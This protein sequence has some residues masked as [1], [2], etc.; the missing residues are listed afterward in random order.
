MATV[1]RKIT[2]RDIAQVGVHRP[3]SA[4]WFGNARTS[5]VILMQTLS[6]PDSAR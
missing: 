3:Q 4:I 2:H 1:K 5:S 6:Q